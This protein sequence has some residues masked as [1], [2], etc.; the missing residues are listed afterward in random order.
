MDS[1]KQLT[2][3]QRDNAI[4]QSLLTERQRKKFQR[5]KGELDALEECARLRDKLREKKLDE[6]RAL[7]AVR[8]SSKLLSRE[9]REWALAAYDALVDLLTTEGFAS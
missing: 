2:E 6:Q 5:I 7:L 1:P 8:L 9:Q 3:L 4:L